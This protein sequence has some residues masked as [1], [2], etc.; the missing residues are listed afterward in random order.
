MRT[1][2]LIQGI[3]HSYI[4]TSQNWQNNT[5]VFSTNPC[6]HKKN[7][8]RRFGWQ[9]NPSSENMNLTKKKNILSDGIIEVVYTNFVSF[10]FHH[11]MSN[12]SLVGLIQIC[13]AKYKMQTNV[14]NITTNSYPSL[15]TYSTR[16]F[17]SKHK[18]GSCDKKKSVNGLALF[19]E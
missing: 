18:Y 19:G 2:M 16:Y 14:T 4:Y 9:F 15:S 8:L 12:V 13:E 17:L 5:Q 10:F 7:C 11:E 1:I 3:E 6:F